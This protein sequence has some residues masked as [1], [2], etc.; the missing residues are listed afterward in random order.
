MKVFKTTSQFE[1]AVQ[2][3]EETMRD[4]GIHISNYGSNG[5]MITSEK[6][7]VS[8][9]IENMGDRSSEFPRIFDEDRLVV[10]ED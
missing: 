2:K 3:I 6:L 5:L 1:V 8:A 7:G 4:A 10:H 9:W